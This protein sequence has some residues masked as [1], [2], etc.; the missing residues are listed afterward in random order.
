MADE[1]ETQEAEAAAE[2]ALAET[3]K[4]SKNPRVGRPKKNRGRVQRSLHEANLLARE[5]DRAAAQERDQLADSVAKTIK[6]TRSKHRTRKPLRAP[7]T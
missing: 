2:A 3:G 5:I 4:A 6:D 7:V 1:E